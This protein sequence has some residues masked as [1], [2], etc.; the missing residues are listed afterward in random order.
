MVGAFR[1]RIMNV[2][3]SL[4]PAFPGLDAQRQALE[5]GAKISGCTVHLVDEECDHGPIVLQAVVSIHDD[6]TEESLSGRI[7]EQEH[8]IYPR[9]VSLFLAGL[10]VEGRRVGATPG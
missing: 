5:Y 4:L 2:H 9:A 6:D 7:L 1:G 8:L 3:P 10:H